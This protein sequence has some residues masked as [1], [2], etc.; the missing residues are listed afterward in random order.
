MKR[1]KLHQWA[2][3][4]LAIFYINFILFI[5]STVSNDGVEDEADSEIEIP[6]DQQQQKNNVVIDFD[7]NFIYFLD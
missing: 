3:L 1:K 6:G 5:G 4:F 2:K 7:F